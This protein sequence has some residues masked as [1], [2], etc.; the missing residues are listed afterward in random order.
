[1]LKL[2]NKYYLAIKQKLIYGD[3]TLTY[4]I[5]PMRQAD[6]AQVVEI[7]REAFPTQW[8]PPNY[9]QELQ[10]HLARYIVICDD[11]R[12][13]AEPEVKPESGLSWLTSRIK[14][15]LKRKHP[16]NDSSPAD[17]HYIIGFAGIWVMADEAH[18]TN[19]AVRKQY[20]RLGI[21]ELLLI[22]TIDL[23]QE[24][25]TSIMTLEVRASNLTAQNLYRKYG[26]TQVGI[27]RGYYLDNREDG[28]LMSTESINSATFQARLR[29]L[30]EA[31]AQKNGLTG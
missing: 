21:G 26:F 4:S 7:D 9:R 20:Q 16:P 6:L 19:I 22:S 25:K 13:V 12:T 10:N 30:R 28:I 18:L 23:A 17:R 11:N 31:L 14:Q 29:Q 1:M 5:R 2:Q 3:R 27:R 24:M 8:P 15:W